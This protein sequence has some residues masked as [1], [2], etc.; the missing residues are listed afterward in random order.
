[1][2]TGLAGWS[3]YSA[4]GKHARQQE[5][6]VKQLEKSTNGGRS[7]IVIRSGAREKVLNNA[8]EGIPTRTEGVTTLREELKFK[9][10][11]ILR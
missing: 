5:G 7:K 10:E 3:S 8:T 9:K 6:S 4:S 2:F 11:V 1:M